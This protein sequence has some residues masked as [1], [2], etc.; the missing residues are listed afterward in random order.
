MQTGALVVAPGWASM[1]ASLETAATRMHRRPAL[2]LHRPARSAAVVLGL[3]VAGGIFGACAAR[4]GPLGPGLDGVLA[5]DAAGLAPGDAAAP[6]PFRVD[7]RGLRVPRPGRDAPVA[8]Y[9]PGAR[10]GLS[11][12]V[13]FLPGYLAPEDQYESIGRAL[14][15]RGFLVAVRGRFGPFVSDREM[16][17]SAIRL[18]DWLIAEQGADPNRIGI[19]GHSMGGKDAVL[20]ALEDPRFRAVVAIDP[21]DRGDPSVVHGD[22]PRLAA[23]LLLIGTELGS[24]A[25]SICADRRFDYRRFFERAP[26]GT[27]EMTLLGADHVQVMDDPE[28]FGLGICRCGTA[29]S[30][31]VRITTRR[32]TVRFFLEHL[33][34]APH[35]PW[36]LGRAAVVRVRGASPGEVA[37][38]F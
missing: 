38:D 29:D 37:D 31:V 18:A 28:R 34:S 9:R 19:A 8:L 7:A 10:S 27:I 21:D 26:A 4:L 30:S 23:P 5:R 14:A 36:Q 6:G 24:N 15:S 13:V 20:T 16:A 32:A 35:R 11:P 33:A 1:P 22:L 25:A 17:N 2:S 3:A 12:A